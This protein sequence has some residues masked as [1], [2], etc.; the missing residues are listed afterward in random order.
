MSQSLLATLWS[1]IANRPSDASPT[2]GAADSLNSIQDSISA[3]ECYG[4]LDTAGGLAAWR[5]VAG[6]EAFVHLN[7]VERAV[8]VTIGFADKGGNLRIHTRLFQRDEQASRHIAASC[9]GTSGCV[10]VAARTPRNRL[11][12]AQAKVRVVRQLQADVVRAFGADVLGEWRDDEDS[13]ND[14]MKLLRDAVTNAD[15]VAWCAFAEACRL[16]LGLVAVLGGSE[17][18][19]H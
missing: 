8:A 11:I 1:R 10:L 7:P 13:W 17:L 14:D 2:E 9:A 12:L 6:A 16:D 4:A 3:S 5:E 18:C 15:R 19:V